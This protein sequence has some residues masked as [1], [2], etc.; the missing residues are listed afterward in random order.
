MGI[1][2]ITMGNLAFG[3]S[4]VID[5][6][7]NV[8]VL[9]PGETPYEGE[10]IVTNN[11]GLETNQTNELETVL[12]GAD[13]AE[14]ELTKDIA[15]I[16]SALEEGQDPT[17]LG[18]ALATAAGGSIGSSLIDSGTVERIGDATIAETEFAT[19]GLEQLGL[20]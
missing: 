7:G 17:Q 8:R 12:I 11:A 2:V 15:E 6:F 9:N 13:G 19:Q 1:G 16:F 4:M 18:D 3:Q 5:V 10:V 20:S 14:V